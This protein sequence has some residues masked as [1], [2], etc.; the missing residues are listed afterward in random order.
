MNTAWQPAA[1]SLSL[2]P[3]TAD[4]WRIN[5][6]RPA[7]DPLHYRALLDATECARADRYRFE[8]D[9]NR[10]TIVRGALRMVL[11]RY[12]G[13]PTADIAFVF[14]KHGKPAL[15]PN[16]CNEPI[17]FNVSH[18]GAFALIGVTRDHAIGVD[19]EEIERKVSLEK[20][21][22]RFFSPDEVTRLRQFPQAEQRAAFFACWT[23][24]E[25]FIK[26]HGDGLSL[27]LDSF[28]VTLD[29]DRPPRLLRFDGEPS[30]DTWTLTAPDVSEGYAG[31]VCVAVSTVDFRFFDF[32]D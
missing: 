15:A 29:P 24:K 12:T 13:V 22:E 14:S 7:I 20:I 11:A 2:V 9:R 4:V 19:V 26:A 6:E 28:S 25:A 16:T 8:A 30:I 31:A 5:L 32:E 17:T 3:D 27:A 18:S 1:P 21:A 23:R 10:F